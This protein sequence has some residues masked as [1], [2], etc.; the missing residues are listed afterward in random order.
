MRL[1]INEKSGHFFLKM[2]QGSEIISF[3]LR[4]KFFMFK[5]IFPFNYI[6]YSETNSEF[7]IFN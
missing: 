1:T 3:V 5:A 4:K 6:T 2:R 7:S